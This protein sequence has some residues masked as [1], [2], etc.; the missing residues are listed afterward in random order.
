MK[1]KVRNKNLDLIDKLLK[2]IPRRP[3]DPFVQIEN[4]KKRVYIV[5]KK[6]GMA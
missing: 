5:E 1:K 4:L 2:S 6:L 3:D